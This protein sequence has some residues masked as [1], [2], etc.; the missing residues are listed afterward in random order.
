MYFIFQL[1]ILVRRLTITE[2][3]ESETFSIAKD[4]LMEPVSLL[5]R[6]TTSLL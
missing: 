5:S 2:Q 3:L 6:D 4:T 1:E